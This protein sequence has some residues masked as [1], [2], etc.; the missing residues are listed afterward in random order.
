MLLRK[1]RVRPIRKLSSDELLTK[2]EM[3]ENF[4][5][6]KKVTYTLKVLLNS[7]TYSFH[8]YVRNRMHSPNIKIGK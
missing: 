8:C 2:Q 6:Y 4:I 5:I 1:V 3:K 7:V